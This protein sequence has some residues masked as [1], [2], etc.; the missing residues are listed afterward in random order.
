MTPGSR[1]SLISSLAALV[2]VSLR[3]S[4]ADWPIVLAAGVMCTLAATLLAAGVMYGDAVA[5]ASL[6]RSLADAPATGVN[7]EASARIGADSRE[8]VDRTVSAAIDEALG[9]VPRS[10]FRTARS[11]SFALSIQPESGVRDLATFGYS[12][13][14]EDHATLVSGA[15]ATDESSPD[16]PVPV[17]ISDRAA[18]ARDLELGDSE[19]VESRV[20]PG[21]FVPLRIV[22]IF[23][24]D[25][26]D[27]PFWRGE[28]QM[29]EG[30]ESTA[31][32]TTYGPFMTTL[33]NVLARTT[34]TQVGVGWRAIPDFSA[35]TLA[36][37]EPLAAR[38]Q[39]LSGRIAGATGGSPAV[40][41]TTDLPAILEQTS[42]SLLVSRA[43]VLVL[44]IQL[45]I[46]A[47]YAVLLSAALLVEHRRVDTT[48]LRSRGAGSLRIAG[49]AAAEGLV[50]VVAA[51]AIGPWLALAALHL[52]DLVGPL[53]DI[54]L[55]LD[56]VVGADAYLAAAG[57]GLLCLV[58]LALPAFLSAR[59][60]AGVQ[61]E[62][63]RGQTRSLGQRLG[64]DLALL[65]VAAI[66]LFQLRQYGGPL[67]AS[68][69]GTVGVDPLLIA[70][71]AIGLLAGAIVAL[72]LI[73][74]A[75]HVLE[76]GTVRGRGLVPSLSARQVAR[77]PLRYT[78]A[79]LLLTLA[80]SMGIFAVS[81]AATWTASQDDQAR[82][83]VGADVRVTPSRRADAIAPTA[84]G[85]A[86]AA[87][88]GVTKTSPVARVEAGLPTGAATIVGID[89]V[90]APAVVTMRPDLAAASL[91][92]LFAP[93]VAGRPA[94]DGLRLPGQPTSLRVRAGL[95]VRDLRT[96]DG[97][98]TQVDPASIAEWR[99]ITVSAV[100]RDGRG[101]LHRFASDPAPLGDGGTTVIDLGGGPF[102]DPLDLIALEVSLSLPPDL[103]SN[104]ATVAVSSVEAGR[105][106]VFDPVD[107]TLASGWRATSAF[108]SQPHQVVTE[109]T[110][111]GDLSVSTG[112]PG[113][114]AIPGRDDFGR[115]LVVTFAPAALSMVGATPIPVVVNDA[116][117][118]ATGRDV[119]D[120]LSMTIGGVSRLV[121]L[122]GVV[123]AFPA[124]DAGGPVV[125]MD[126]P[127]LSLLQFEGSDAT[128]AS[129]E[130][131]LAV[132]PGRSDA[133]SAALRDGSIGSESV[134]SQA[135]RA[136]AL[137]TDPVAL[138]VIGAFAIG[139]IAAAVFA[140]LGFVVN[141]AV[142]ARERVTEF[143]LL[144][145]VGLS[146]GQL[147]AWL[148][149]E[150]AGLAAIS[151]VAGTALGLLLAW[152]VLPFVTVT[153]QA[154]AP[155]PAV[156]IVVPWTTIALLVGVSTV[157]LAVTIGMIALLLRRI[158]L[159]S[160][161]RM[162]ED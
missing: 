100:V 119:G 90:A 25:D 86:Y 135:E 38:V 133:V 102:D 114:V 6:H 97:S 147:S 139:F 123:H 33:P 46:L 148:S 79:A 53:V 69:K 60:L 49:M 44:T 101:M 1:R 7:I 105:D 108:F 30:V 144:R 162:G 74:L 59:S 82:Y 106:G 71:P 146:G 153:Q 149:L 131:W 65:I 19:Y 110:E 72:R 134:V 143:A 27:D 55:R 76:R 11:D 36:D 140:V 89:A 75:A 66:G 50:L 4:R 158:G 18:E 51:V 57:A 154:V 14:L 68:V 21:F 141:A 161:L 34:P 118:R 77:R 136:R 88:D 13:G 157:V 61:G 47:V 127:T 37:V 15:W 8:D 98:E 20:T 31:R 12:E 160:V 9:S 129:G 120:A 94:V 156:E 28:P 52:F 73:P 92:D 63:A 124:T 39:A 22:G 56:P 122:T 112:G 111:G 87:L 107:T 5:V 29:I 32:F 2:R 138:G 151:I 42:Q 78:R 103:M 54:G 121:R 84:V 48:M 40:T 70:T 83:Q 152:V 96:T 104:D 126:L 130:W 159:A 81:Y 109:R 45:V 16:Q 117:I 116:F 99:G 26:P 93:L 113:L 64:L 17:A 145:A 95:D 132:D 137:A 23:H 67:T 128:L 3:R 115:G 80:M 58:A 24:V 155:V 91:P 62:M 41:V 85:P 142:S 35:T 10:V 125:V 43:G 150:S